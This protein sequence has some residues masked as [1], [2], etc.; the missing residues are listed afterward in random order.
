MKRVLDHAGSDWQNMVGRHGEERSFQL[1]LSL[2]KPLKA[3]TA[4]YLG[5]SE[6]IP[7]YL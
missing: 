1:N 2:F 3:Q 5:I 6:K 7:N 4:R